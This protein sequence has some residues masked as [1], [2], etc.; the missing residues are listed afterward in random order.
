MPRV[1]TELFWGIFLQI[2]CVQSHQFLLPS[3]YIILNNFCSLT[4]W[5]ELIF[6]MVFTSY[7][8]Q[9]MFILWIIK[10]SFCAKAHVTIQYENSSFDIIKI[11][12]KLD[13]INEG[14]SNLWL[15]FT[16]LRLN[17]TKCF[18]L[19]P[20]LGIEITEPSFKLVSRELWPA[21]PVLHPSCS[22]WLRC[23]SWKSDIV[24]QFTR[25]SDYAFSGNSVLMWLLCSC[26]LHCGCGHFLPCECA[27]LLVWVCEKL[28][29]WGI[30]NGHS[31]C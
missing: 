25:I 20:L 29:L 1:G 31:H 12:L 9:I 16:K 13:S 21:S 27:V 19:C 24:H 7:W 11:L 2:S 28:V 5:L 14:E 3:T 17:L 23:L 22:S 18:K 30:W 10:W 15:W 4:G 8:R 26:A 6:E